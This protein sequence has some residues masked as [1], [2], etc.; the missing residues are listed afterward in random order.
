MGVLKIEI[1]LSCY[2]KYP[3]RYR[4]PSQT[5]AAIPAQELTTVNY[6]ILLQQ[7]LQ[8]ASLA[9]ICQTE[10]VHTPTSIHYEAYQSVPLSTYQTLLA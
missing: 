9:K 7:I 1:T 10:F 6:P 2:Q 5:V 4:V 3:H 8:C